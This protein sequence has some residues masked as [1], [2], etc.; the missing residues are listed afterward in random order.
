MSST[1]FIQGTTGNN[2]VG[3]VFNF[4]AGP[5]VMPLAVLE[6]IQQELLNYKGTGMSVLEMSHRS[7]AFEDI[8]HQTEANI[9]KLY[10]IPA[11]YKVLFLQGGASL[12]FTMVPV[13]LLAKDASADYILTGSWSQT[14]FKEGKKSG[15]VRVA[16]T[17]EASN[18][19]RIPAQAELQL[20]P[21]AAYLHFTS[22]N[23]IFGTQWAAEPVSLDGV[24]LVCDTSSDILSR[25]LDISKYGVLYGGAQK[26]M[27]PAGLTIVIIR[28][29][30]LARTP[31]NL[32][33]ML[34]YRLLSEKESLHNTP[35]TFAIYATGLVT[36]WLLENGGLAET[37]KRNS[38]KAGLLYQ[39]IDNS[40]GFYKGHAQPASRSNMNVTFRLPTEALEKA[41]VKEATAQGMDGLKGY[42]TVGGIRASIYNAFPYEGV[43]ALVQFMQAFQD[44]NR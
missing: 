18:F 16:G 11:N 9:R 2:A 25:P 37:A 3:R 14:A 34:D 20:D 6:Q 44:N 12:Q 8:I 36:N 31:S 29:D 43:E 13:N 1:S 32:P 21:N 40:E 42:R 26:N 4:S 38:A 5:A 27:G 39:A 15:Q 19:D 7:A 10:N 30:L 28:E 23:T 35:P 22:N 24:P 33:A 41:F 17:S